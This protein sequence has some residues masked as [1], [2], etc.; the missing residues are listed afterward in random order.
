MH[1]ALL[2]ALQELIPRSNESPMIHKNITKSL[3]LGEGRILAAYETA[4]FLGLFETLWDKKS[5]RCFNELLPDVRHD[6]FHEYT[7]LLKKEH[8]CT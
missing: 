1:V 8:F 7:L 2:L 3:R 5:N 4:C 6:D